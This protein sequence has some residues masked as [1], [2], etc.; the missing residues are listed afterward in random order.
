MACFSF[1]ACR[2]SDILIFRWRRTLHGI[3]QSRQTRHHRRP[4]QAPQALRSRRRLLRYRRGPRGR[5]PPPPRHDC[6]CRKIPAATESRVPSFHRHQRFRLPPCPPRSQTP[7]PRSRR[8][9]PPPPQVARRYGPALPRRQRPLRLPSSSVCRLPRP[10]ILI[11]SLACGFQNEAAI[12]AS[13]QV[14]LDLTF[15]ARRELPFQVP[16]NQMDRV[17][18]IHA[19]PTSS[20]P[21]WVG[22]FSSPQGAIRP[23][24]KLFKLEHSGLAFVTACHSVYNGVGSV[25][26]NFSAH[27]FRSVFLFLTGIF[28]FLATKVRAVI[29]R[30]NTLGSTTH[31]FDPDRVRTM[32]TSSNS[33]AFQGGR[34]PTQTH[35]LNRDHEMTQAVLHG[36]PGSAAHSPLPYAASS[37]TSP[38]ASAPWPP[39]PAHGTSAGPIVD[40]R[41]ASPAHAAPHFALLPPAT[42]AER[43]SPVC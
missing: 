41:G 23:A 21:A 17:P 20:G 19:C 8:H 15:H 42:R 27:F 39:S 34:M 24:E 13:I 37:T 31:L 22:P 2:I 11:Q 28:F 40:T 25:K 38:P 18:A 14:P 36:N 43:D 29:V 1:D 26:T 9:P 4:G 7:R 30:W 32:I 12:P 33:L 35:G 6:P 16:A 5:H 3:R 10:Q